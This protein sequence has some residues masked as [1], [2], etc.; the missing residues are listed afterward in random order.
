MSYTTHRTV[1][2]AV[3]TDKTVGKFIE[4]LDFDEDINGNN[5]DEFTS[6]DALKRGFDSTLA[7]LLADTEKK[8]KNYKGEKKVNAFVD[9]FLDKLQDEDGHYD[10]SEVLVLKI[11]NNKFVVTF[12]LECTT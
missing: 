9:T 4:T 7:M 8:T 12:I 5:G 2:Q 10:G 6:E 11:G 1:V 3:V